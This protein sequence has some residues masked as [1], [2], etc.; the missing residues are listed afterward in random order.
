MHR[1]VI[2]RVGGLEVKKTCLTTIVRVIRRV[3]GLE[4]QRFDVTQILNVI[5]RV[6]GLEAPC[7]SLTAK[8]MS[9]PPCRWLRR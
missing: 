9:Y 4:V 2:R 1:Y 7:S 6:G 3:G 8:G 5:R